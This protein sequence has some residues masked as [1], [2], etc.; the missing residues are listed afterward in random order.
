MRDREPVMVLNH[1]AY[2]DRGSVL[3]KISNRL[4]HFGTQILFSAITPL[5]I[6]AISER[7]FTR[8]LIAFCFGRSYGNRYQSVIDSFEGRYGAAMA[9]GLKR[10]PK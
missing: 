7:S 9:E 5:L 10:A 1:Q 6:P 2:R 4:A 8:R 3:G